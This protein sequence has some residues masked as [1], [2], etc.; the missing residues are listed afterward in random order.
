MRHGVIKREYRKQGIL[1]EILNQ[2]LEYCKQA[3]F[4]QVV[5]CFVLS[6]N[7]ILAQMIKKEFYLTSIECHAE[8]GQIGWLS[9]YL[10]NE[11]KNAF[12]FRSGM[13]QF[14]KKMYYSSEGTAKILLDKLDKIAYN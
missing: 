10:N 9:H 2:V 11:L 4:V 13:A 12:S 5:C 6:N 3:G 7:N 1:S 8:Y 14:T